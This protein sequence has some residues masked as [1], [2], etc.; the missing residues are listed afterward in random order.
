MLYLNPARE[1]RVAVPAR[2]RA[3]ACGLSALLLAG[4]FTPPA[5]VAAAAAPAAAADKRPRIGLV[6]G[7]GGARGA[8][9]IGVLEVLEQLRV[10]VDCVAGTSMGALVAGV[11]VSGVGP[12]GMRQALA[13]ADWPDLFRDD[14]GFYDM[15]IRNKRL[16]QAFPPAT[17]MGVTERGLRFPPGVVSGQ[18]IKAF[19]NQLVGADR[20]E[21]LIEELPLPLAIIAADIGNGERV[22]MREGSLTQAMRASMSVPG[23]MAPIVVNER[24]LVDGGLVDNIPVREVRELCRADRV[25]AVNVGSPMLDAEDVGSLLTV[26]VQMINLLTAQNVTQSLASLKPDDILIRPNLDGITASDFERSS[27]TADRGR[28]AAKDEAVYRRLAEL[29]VSEAEYAAWR[30]RL[31][32]GP[33]PPVRV[34]EIQVAEMERVNPVDVRRG[35]SQPIGEPL[36]TPRLDADLL[37]VYGTGHFESVDYSVLGQRDRNILRVTPTEKSWGPNFL[38][39]GLGLST[40]KTV[41]TYNLAVAY[42]K[43]L[44]NPLGGEFLAIGQIGNELRAGAEFYQPFEATRRFFVQP[45]VMYQRR[46]QPIFQDDRRVAELQVSDAT[47]DLKL[48]YRVGTLGQATVGWRQQRRWS[49]VSVGRPLFDDYD[50]NTNG[51]LV[52]VDLDQL[53]QI[54]QPRSGWALSSSYFEDSGGDY[55]KLS[56][57]VRGAAQSDGWVLQGRASFSGSAHG[58]LPVYNAATLGGPLNLSAFSVGQ[59]VGD[60]AAFASVRLERVLT[61]LPLGLRGDMRLGASAEAGRLRTL[62]T[63]TQRT[64]WQDSYAVYI[65]GEVPL[66]L[67]FFGVAHSP[68]SGYS[69]IYIVIGTP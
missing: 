12:D 2:R 46:D 5:V 49:E 8:A 67:L 19:F 7:G 10:P 1:A 42:R 66:G 17:E 47:A 48:G 61:K 9:H 53:D 11:W 28:A 31:D 63:E 44:I 21:R 52:D 59:L 13:G 3:W 64:G 39:F 35:I 26:S 40:D 24:K 55:G 4:A 38:R 30:Q 27:E 25:I 56:A 51:V 33:R 68:S 65:G 43:T 37:R 6:L 15:T 57:S 18:K 69:N 41:S 34:D 14:P 22:V 16:A 50:V 36:D 45:R 20:G 29:S 58:R 23:L 32:T 54:F 60:D 62:F